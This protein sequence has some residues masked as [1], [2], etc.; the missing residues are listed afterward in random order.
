[1]PYGVGRIAGQMMQVALRA[2]SD[3]AKKLPVSRQ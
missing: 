2:F 1:M 3:L